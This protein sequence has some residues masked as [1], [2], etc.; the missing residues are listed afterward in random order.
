MKLKK[1]FDKFP[2]VETKNLILREI[3]IS[4]AKD[5]F[6]YYTGK[7]ICKYLDWNGPKNIEEAEEYIYIWRKGYEENWILPFA[8]VDRSTNKMIGS[9]IFSEFIGKRAD[10]GYEICETYWKK[11]LMYEALDKLL[12]IIIRELD[13]KRI[14]S[15]VFKENIASKKLLNKLRFKEEGLL[16]K[17]SY[18]IVREECIDSYIYALVL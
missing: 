10:L 6:E 8:I 14:Q 11:G 12:P 15:I 18:H 17:Y 7:N 1:I 13:L 5:F 16:K 9:V 2:R 4:D 3:Q